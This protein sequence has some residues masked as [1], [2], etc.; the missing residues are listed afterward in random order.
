MSNLMLSKKD[1][2]SNQY[3]LSFVFYFNHIRLFQL[4]HIQMSFY[5]DY[6]SIFNLLDY[7]EILT[8]K[9]LQ[10]D[11]KLSIILYIFPAVLKL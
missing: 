6:E 2:E 1:T 8:S 3:E 9:Q 11:G 10:I 4:Y 5:Y 7:P